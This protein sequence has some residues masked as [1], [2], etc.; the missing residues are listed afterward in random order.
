MA[1]KALTAVLQEVYVQGVSSSKSDRNHLP[2]NQNTSSQPKNWGTM[3]LASELGHRRAVPLLNIVRCPK[4]TQ[5][6]SRA[7]K[8][9]RRQSHVRAGVRGVIDKA[10]HNGG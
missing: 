7:S 5:C 2:I 9:N 3:A 1:E 4:A 8:Q 6:G 10:L